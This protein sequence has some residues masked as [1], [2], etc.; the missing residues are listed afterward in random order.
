MPQSDQSPEAMLMYNAQ[1]A[2]RNHTDLG[3]LSFYWAMVTFRP[4]LL[5][6]AISG[7]MVLLQMVSMLIVTAP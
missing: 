4:K 7:S 1:P 3:D 5:P 6:R 2:T